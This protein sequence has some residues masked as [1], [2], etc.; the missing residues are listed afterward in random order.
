MSLSN[1]ELPYFV[2]KQVDR[3]TRRLIETLKNHQLVVELHGCRVLIIQLFPHPAKGSEIRMPFALLDY[4]SNGWILLYRGSQGRWQSIPNDR[5][6]L[7][8]DDK[9][10]EI[11]DDPYGVFWRQ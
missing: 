8:A 2:R 9:V 1:Q 6:S 5:P 3:A 4:K 10:T 11:I 7:S